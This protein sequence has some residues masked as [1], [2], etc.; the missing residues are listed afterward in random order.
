M[1][2]FPTKDN[3]WPNKPQQ[4]QKRSLRNGIAEKT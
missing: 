4:K 2:T 1:D 3:K